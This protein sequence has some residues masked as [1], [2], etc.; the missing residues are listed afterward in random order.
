MPD[1]TSITAAIGGLKAATEVAKFLRDTDQAFKAA[2][3][4]LRIAEL[5]DGLA[6]AKLSLAEIQDVLAERD[7]EIKRLSAALKVRDEVVRHNDSYYVKAA[8]GKAIGDPYCSFCFEAKAVLVH[9]NQSPKDRLQSVCP[10]CKNV[11]NWQRRQNPTP[12]AGA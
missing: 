11:F 9:I 3:L 8:D 6:T 1:I 4:K 2:D 10:N 7:A 12:N 5:V